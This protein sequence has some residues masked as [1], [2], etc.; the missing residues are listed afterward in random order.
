MFSCLSQVSYFKVYLMFIL[1]VCLFDCLLDLYTY[2]VHKIKQNEKIQYCSIYIYIDVC[3]CVCVCVN[4]LCHSS[5]YLRGILT[6]LPDRVVLY[7]GGLSATSIWLSR[8]AW[9]RGTLDACWRWAVW[10]RYLLWSTG[11]LL[12]W[13]ISCLVCAGF[14]SPDALAQID[15][16]P[17]ERIACVRSD[18]VGSGSGSLVHHLSW[19]PSLG[20][21]VQDANILSWV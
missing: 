7:E 9:G 2:F 19:L 18:I 1:F 21:L 17:S 15:P 14:L 11:L 5:L 8:G 6:S 16:V 10:S 13:C 4:S 3:V 20:L 12:C